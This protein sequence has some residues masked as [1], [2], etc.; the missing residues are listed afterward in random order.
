M[1]TTF[2]RIMIISRHI[3]MKKSF[4]LYYFRFELLNHR[5]QFDYFQSLLP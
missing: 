2:E 5:I 4:Y 1:D 3:D